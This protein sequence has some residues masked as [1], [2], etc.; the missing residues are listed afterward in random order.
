M[1]YDGYVDDYS[2]L[3]HPLGHILSES[4]CERAHEM[5]VSMC[6]PLYGVKIPMRWVCHLRLNDV[7]P[8]EG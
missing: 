1:G 8:C 2:F 3:R 5:G 6:V 7:Y 4:A